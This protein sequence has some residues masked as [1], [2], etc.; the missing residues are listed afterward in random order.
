MLAGVLL[1]QATKMVYVK[2]KRKSAARLGPLAPVMV[3][4]LSG[5]GVHSQTR[6]QIV[7]DE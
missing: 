6:V 1:V 7:R 3:R 2:K 5:Q 4:P